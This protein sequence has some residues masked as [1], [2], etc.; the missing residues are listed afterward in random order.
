MNSFPAVN[1]VC[2]AVWSE[3]GDDSVTGAASRRQ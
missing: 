3:P 2:P 1:A